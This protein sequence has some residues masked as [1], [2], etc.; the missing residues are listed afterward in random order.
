MGWFGRISGAVLVSS[1]MGA[2][3]GQ[4]EEVKQPF[5]Y[6]GLESTTRTRITT[7]SDTTHSRAVGTVP[8]DTPVTV[9]VNLGQHYL[10]KMPYGLVGWTRI[11]RGYDAPIRGIY[12]AGD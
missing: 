11:P 3:G 5:Y 6:V 1:A 4:S 9:L 12:F 8:A 10:I 2:C 7:Y